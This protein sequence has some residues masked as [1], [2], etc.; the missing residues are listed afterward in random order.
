MKTVADYLKHASETEALVAD[1]ATPE[2]QDQL[3]QIADMW[4]ALA[5]DREEFLQR[6]P[7]KV[8]GTARSRAS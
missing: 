1:G 4:R 3:R 6:H 7:A 8:Q 5:K 2:Q